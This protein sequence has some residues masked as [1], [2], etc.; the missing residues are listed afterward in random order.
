M[1][2]G[3]GSTSPTRIGQIK[4]DKIAAAAPA[5][6]VTK[7]DGKSAVPTFTA[8]LAEAGPPINDE[9]IKAIRQAIANGQYPLDPKAIA[10]KMIALDLPKAT[11]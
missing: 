2:N 3:V 6:T 9:K 5:E 11:A 4:D 10:K 1:I 8:A 7:V